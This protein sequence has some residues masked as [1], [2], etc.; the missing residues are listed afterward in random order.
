MAEHNEPVCE[1]LGK[2]SFALNEK[3]FLIEEIETQLNSQLGY[4]NVDTM[5][6]S[7]SFTSVQNNCKLV[8]NMFDESF[9]SMAQSA[10]ESD[11]RKYMLHFSEFVLDS[12][13][14]AIQR[15]ESAYKDSNN[16]FKTLD[17][18]E[19]K[20]RELSNG[21]SDPVTEDIDDLRGDIFNYLET[22][23]N[24]RR[25]LRRDLVESEDIV[26]STVLES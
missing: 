9:V 22:L 13:D 10:L 19:P 18:Y 12:L 5:V 3:R 1:E 16:M 21:M 14:I 15:L 6:I 17:Q 11:D 26:T 8:S 7:Q 20:L 24:V 23:R 25:D 4:L 2:V